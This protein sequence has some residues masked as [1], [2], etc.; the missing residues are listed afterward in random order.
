MIDVIDSGNVNG[1]DVLDGDEYGSGG[2][3]G[4]DGRGRGGGVDV[5]GVVD[6]HW[7][8]GDGV[9]GDAD[10]R[11]GDGVGGGADGRGGHW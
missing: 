8:S 2:C 11:V 5:C 7:D 4:G 9:D 1:L 6:D 10:S 3:H